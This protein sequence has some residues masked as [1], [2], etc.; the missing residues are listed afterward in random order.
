MDRAFLDRAFLVININ[1]RL[2]DD[3]GVGMS[4]GER[5]SSRGEI[6]VRGPSRGW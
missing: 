1:R 3:W 5:S 6:F 2:R 4:Q